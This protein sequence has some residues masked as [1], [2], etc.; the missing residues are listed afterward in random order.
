MRTN[1]LRERAAALADRV[2]RR[3]RATAR[4]TRVDAPTLWR[5]AS[6]AAVL[7]LVLGIFLTSRFAVRAAEPA[8]A[9][10]EGVAWAERLG[11]RAAPSSHSPCCP[12]RP[13]G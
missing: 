5:M 1:G 9:T 10:S 6:H 8:T 11:R 3:W 7:A 12:P 13:V 4:L 2:E